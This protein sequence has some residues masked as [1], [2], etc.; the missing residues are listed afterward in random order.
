VAGLR[1]VT[2]SEAYSVNEIES[3]G[4]KAAR[5][6]GAP[7]A[8][9]LRFGKALVHHLAQQR[10]PQEIRMALDALPQGPILT[11]ALAPDTS[12]LGQS[13][14][15]AQNAPLPKRVP[16][17]PELKATLLALAHQTYVP[18]SETSRV[19]GAGAGLTDND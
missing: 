4:A 2:Q 6:A 8:Q 5:G 15:D 19:A 16:C 13:Y 10:D 9:A 18:A 3:L 7:P 1:A 12:A 11:F 17:A 14:R